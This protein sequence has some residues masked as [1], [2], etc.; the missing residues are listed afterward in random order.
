LSP[1]RK[2]YRGALIAN[3]G[4]SPEEAKEALASGIVDA[5]AFGTAFLANP[6]LPNRISAGYSLN[7]PDQSTFYSSGP[8]GYTDYPLSN[9]S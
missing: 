4:Y 5:I 7:A 2:H 3:M 8:K 1:A 9:K 6:D